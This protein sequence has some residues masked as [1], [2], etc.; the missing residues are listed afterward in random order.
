MYKDICDYV[1]IRRS[2]ETQRQA[3]ERRMPCDN[4]GRDWNAAAINQGTQKTA[5][6]VPEARKRQRRVVSCKVH[7][8][9]KYFDVRLLTSRTRR[10]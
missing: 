7:G 9:D 5:S 4:R 10:H 6:K 3:H 8:V 1:L 2:E